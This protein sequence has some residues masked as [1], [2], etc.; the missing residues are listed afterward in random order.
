VRPICKKNQHGSVR[1]VFLTFVTLK[2]DGNLLNPDWNPKERPSLIIPVLG[3]V[4]AD[5]LGPMVGFLFVIFRCL[6]V[7]HIFR[8]MILVVG[9]VFAFLVG[10]GNAIANPSGEEP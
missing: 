8:P 1:F 5:V 3:V 6:F 7:V 10:S 2:I 9:G 4:I